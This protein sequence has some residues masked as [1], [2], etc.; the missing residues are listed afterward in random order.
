MNGARAARAL[1]V[2]MASC[3]PPALSTPKPVVHAPPSSMRVVRDAHRAAM[4]IIA[5]QGDPSPAVAAFISTSGIGRERGAMVPVVLAGLIESRAGVRATPQADGVR[6]A[7]ETRDTRDGIARIA[8]A[9]TSPVNEKTELGVVRRKVLALAALPRALGD[10]AAIASCEGTL[11]PPADTSLPGAAEIESWRALA[12]VRER[13]AFAV[14]GPSDAPPA[15]ALPNGTAAP[16]DASPDKSN[17]GVYDTTETTS[18]AVVSILWRGDLH[19]LGATRAL[20]QASPLVAMIAATDSAAHVRSVTTAL[21]ARGVCL[22]LRAQI[23][24]TDAE[25]IASIAVLASREARSAIR[26]T[27]NVEPAWSTNAS[28]AA[29]QAALVALATDARSPRTGRR[30]SSS[31][32]RAE[33][34]TR[35]MRSRRR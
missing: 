5:R 3:G 31:V 22:S 34:T 17:L 6:V 27:N 19:V 14:V 24:T 25:R 1:L 8:T 26:E 33:P 10:A 32:W 13:V 7:F 11:A 12:A 35:A 23:D 15:P 18:G 21:S 9:L 28:S 29:E 2:V 30:T 4:A 16:A 20:D